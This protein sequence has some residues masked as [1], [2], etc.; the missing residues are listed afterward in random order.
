MI[1]FIF[2]Q[3]SKVLVGKS[4]KLALEVSNEKT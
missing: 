1:R 2:T 4:K 3:M